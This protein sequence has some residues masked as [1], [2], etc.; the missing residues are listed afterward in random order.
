MRELLGVMLVVAGAG[1]QTSQN[2][3]RTTAV[4]QAA[5][6]AGARVV[7]PATTPESGPATRTETQACVAGKSGADVANAVQAQ[8][9]TEWGD[10]Q[11]IPAKVD[12]R[13]VV[14]GAKDGTG[15]SGVVD[16][17]RRGPCADGE[18]YV[19]LGIHEIP[20][21]LAGPARTSAGSRGVSSAAS[22]RMPVVLSP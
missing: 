5:L 21:E 10:V 20:A 3:A 6:P 8:L 11:I 1:C 9:S 2:E 4:A 7:A 22:G 17:V 13:W 15:V 12:G 14:V 18:V 16:E 19:N